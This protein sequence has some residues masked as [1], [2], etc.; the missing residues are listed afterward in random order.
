MDFQRFIRTHLAGLRVLAVST[1]NYIPGIILDREKLRILG[2][3]REVLP[4]E[5]ESTWSYS[6]SDASMMYGSITANRKMKSGLKV[7]GIFSL[8]GSVDRDLSV[9]IDINDIRGASLN[10]SQLALQPKINQLRNIDRRNRW[11]VIS[12]QLIVMETFFASGFTATFMRND[13]VVTQAELEE[14]TKLNV[15]ASVDYHWQ[16]GK[17]LVVTQNARVPFGVRGFVV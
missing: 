15:E 2:H 12:N 4:D 5:P 14:I 17:Q 6:T 13:Q 9:H 16:A 3:C 8:R 11:R 7:M 1:E 10:T